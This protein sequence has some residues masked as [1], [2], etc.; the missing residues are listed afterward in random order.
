LTKAFE[1]LPQAKTRLMRSKYGVA[2]AGNQ[3]SITFSNDG[4]RNFGRRI[5]LN[6]TTAHKEFR[7][8]FDKILGVMT[9][10]SG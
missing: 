4:R 3:T 1:A 8:N 2:A 5:I 6:S 9:E 7:L 10:F